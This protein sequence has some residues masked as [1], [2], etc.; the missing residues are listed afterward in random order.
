MSPV[1]LVEE[2]L[3]DILRKSYRNA[4][5]GI[6]S[7]VHYVEEQDVLDQLRKEV[8][9]ETLDVHIAKFLDM[10]AAADRVSKK[11]LTSSSL[12]AP[13]V[14]FVQRKSDTAIADKGTE[15]TKASKMEPVIATEIYGD[16]VEELP[17]QYD[18]GSEE[19]NSRRSS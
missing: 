6:L 4:Q 3:D 15:F 17:S 13:V 16:I 10:D 7:A 12:M 14:T 5:S 8:V 1:T 11:L 18:S 9:G 19:P 2:F